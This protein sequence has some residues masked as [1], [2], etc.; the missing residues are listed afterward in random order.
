[1]VTWRVWNHSHYFPATCSDLPKLFLCPYHVRHHLT[2]L[3]L[4]IPLQDF[5][6]EIWNFWLEVLIEAPFSVLIDPFL[7]FVFP[8]WCERFLGQ[9]FFSPTGYLVNTKVLDKIS[10]SHDT[11]KNAPATA[12]DRWVVVT[13]EMPDVREHSKNAKW[14]CFPWRKRGLK[15]KNNNN[16]KIESGPFII[17]TSCC[18]HARVRL[19]HHHL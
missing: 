14:V 19:W 13:N 2:Q 12:P 6:T 7:F 8:H 5:G 17:R 4:C 11:I 1:M 10:S 9:I 18:S 3:S 16:R 15:S